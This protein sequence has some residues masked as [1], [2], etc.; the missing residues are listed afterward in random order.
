MG[1]EKACTHLLRGH[2]DSRESREQRLLGSHL[3]HVQL[4]GQLFL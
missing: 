2:G 3:E 4:L 1:S